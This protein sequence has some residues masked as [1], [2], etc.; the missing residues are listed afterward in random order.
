MPVEKKYASYLIRLWREQTPGKTA[1][2]YVE[3]ESVQ[4]GQKWAFTSLRALHDFLQARSEGTYTDL[5]GS[6]KDQDD[7][8]TAGRR[9]DHEP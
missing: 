8:S 2:C 6:G 4:T 1:A 7:V 3:V 9:V 5:A